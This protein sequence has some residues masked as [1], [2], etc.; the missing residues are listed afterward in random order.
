M[1]FEEGGRMTARALLYG[2]IEGLEANLA[3]LSAQD[4]AEQ[5]DEI[6]RIARD[7]GFSAVSDLAHGFESMLARAP[8]AETLKPW[9]AALGE[10]V[11]CEELDANAVRSWIAALAQR[12]Q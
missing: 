5:V 12:A 11:G 9:V 1:G 10:A 6:R 4:L 3:V 8:K 7:T 2:Q